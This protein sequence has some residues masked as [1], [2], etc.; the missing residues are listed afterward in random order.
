MKTAGEMHR[1]LVDKAD[2]DEEFRNRLL[3]DP[4]GVIQQEFDLELPESLGIQVHENSAE[5]V[6]LVLPPNPRLNEAQL[7]RVAGG[8]EDFSMDW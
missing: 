3:T 1:I 4:K 5:T 7:A 2:E 8:S 6:H